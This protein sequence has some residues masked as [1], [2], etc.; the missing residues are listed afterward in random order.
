LGREIHRETCALR[1]RD[2]QRFEARDAAWQRRQPQRGRANT[3]TMSGKTPMD[4]VATLMKGQHTH[5]AP[6]DSQADALEF[7][8][9]GPACTQEQG[10]S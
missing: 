6:L 5:R 2:E 10:R 3:G 8:K 1:N 9:E 7:M 4:I